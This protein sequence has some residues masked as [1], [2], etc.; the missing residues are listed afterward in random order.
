MPETRYR[1]K[2]GTG[3]ASASEASRSRK[4]QRHDDLKPV[5][6]RR[7]RFTEDALSVVR[8]GMVKGV[9]VAETAE[10]L[11]VT[12]RTVQNARKRIRAE[13][14]QKSNDLDTLFNESYG[15]F[16]AY[17]QK[18]LERGNMREARENRWAIVRLT[19]VAKPERKEVEYT[20]AGG[21]PIEILVNA[22]PSLLPGVVVDSPG[23]SG[24]AVV[25]SPAGELVEGEF[26]EVAAA[27]DG[28]GLDGDGSG[29]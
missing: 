6:K 8:E 28:E 29:A 7:F 22:V 14:A 4:R 9:R 11:G 5:D 18:A 24:A 23:A 12:E 13:W 16:L 3:P 15:R 20:G 1:E 10:I 26:V 17:E 2:A 21:G 27:V 25:A 19:G